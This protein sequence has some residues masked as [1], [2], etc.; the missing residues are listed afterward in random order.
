M[1]I[2]YKNKYSEQ[3]NLLKNKM[4]WIKTPTTHNKNLKKNLMILQ[5]P[6]IKV[7]VLN[8]TKDQK[9]QIQTHRKL[10]GKFQNLI[11]N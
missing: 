6:S 7:Q 2:S 8:K 11:S 10:W 5:R 9:S 4:Q 3:T 1:P